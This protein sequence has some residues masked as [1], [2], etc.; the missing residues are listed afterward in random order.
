MKEKVTGGGGWGKWYI[1]DRG[2]PNASNQKVESE[3]GMSFYEMT[4]EIEKLL[5]RGRN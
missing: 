4:E 1:K 2:T 3:K 5:R